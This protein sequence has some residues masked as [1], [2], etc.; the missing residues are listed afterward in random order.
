MTPRLSLEHEQN[1]TQEENI[2]EVELSVEE[3]ELVEDTAKY[4]SDG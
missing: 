3:E 1:A 2:L 4:D